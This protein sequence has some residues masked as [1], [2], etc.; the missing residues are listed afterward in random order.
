[1]RGRPGERPPA[2]VP[3]LFTAPP[4]RPPA[5]APAGLPLIVPVTGCPAATVTMLEKAKVLLAV[6][7]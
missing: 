5:M 2:A 4:V 7:A 6:F 1:M 3:E